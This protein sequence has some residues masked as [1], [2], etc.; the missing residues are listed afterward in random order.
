MITSETIARDD[1]TMP[2]PPPTPK[3]IFPTHRARARA[4]SRS[5]SCSFVRSIRHRSKAKEE[6][7]KTQNLLI[8]YEWQTWILSS[9]MNFFLVKNENFFLVA[10]YDHEWDNIY[11]IISEL[12]S[13]QI[14]SLTFPPP[15]SPRNIDG[16]GGSGGSSRGL[17]RTGLSSHWW[18]HAVRVSHQWEDLIPKTKS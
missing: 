5:L 14:P 2:T 12:D 1:N 9:R 15:L 10:V 4:R 18:N 13:A 16:G 17:A 7:K 3:K 11:I 8:T 6:E